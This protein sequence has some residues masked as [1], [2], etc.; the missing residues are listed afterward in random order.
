V[1]SM[2]RPTGIAFAAGFAFVPTQAGAAPRRCSPVVAVVVHRH[3]RMDVFRLIERAREL[4]IHRLARAGGDL[5]TLIDTEHT[6]SGAPSFSQAKFGH[7][8]PGGGVV[9]R[10]EVEQAALVSARRYR[11]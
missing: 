11:G 1:A 10:S 6:A 7:S 9:Q 2:I 5:V 3:R 8:R 4:G